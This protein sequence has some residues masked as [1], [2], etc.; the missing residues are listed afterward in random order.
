MAPRKLRALVTRRA[1]GRGCSFL[2]RRE[3]IGR[4]LAQGFPGRDPEILIAASS[5]HG[6]LGCAGIAG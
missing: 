4:V 3:F 5:G 1:G 6:D 2:P